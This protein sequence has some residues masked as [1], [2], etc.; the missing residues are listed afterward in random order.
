MTFSLKTHWSNKTLDLGCLVALRFPLFQ[1]EWPLD[2][3]LANVILFRQVVELADLSDTLWA[4]SSRDGVVGKTRDVF[5]SLLDDY[6]V[7]HTEVTVNNTPTDRAAPSLSLASR[8]VARVSFLEEK[9]DTAVR[10][11]TLL[12]GKSL[13]VIATRNSDYIPLER[14]REKER[15]SERD[16]DLVKNYFHQ[17]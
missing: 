2:D 17:H 7:E 4:E 11:D 10:E 16:A 15:E 8:S 5:L 13:L 9:L 1:W 14:E 12:H 3:V 6:Q